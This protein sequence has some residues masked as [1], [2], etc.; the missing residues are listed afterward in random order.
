MTQYKSL[1]EYSG[2]SALLKQDKIKLSEYVSFKINTDVSDLNSGEFINISVKMSGSAISS[3]Y[4]I[5]YENYSL[6]FNHNNIKYTIKNMLMIEWKEVYLYSYNFKFKASE[7][8]SELIEKPDSIEYLIPNLLISYDE[9]KV[10]NEI[11]NSTN[12]SLN[13]KDN[14]LKV[15][16]EGNPDFNNN[17]IFSNSQLKNTLS[18]KIIFQINTD[19]YNF[20][21]INSISK[22]LTELIGI[23]YGSF[24][25]SIITKFYKNNL[26]IGENLYS[27]KI[28][29]SNK[30]LPLIPYQYSGV[31]SNFINEAF[32]KYIS[33]NEIQKNEIKIISQKVF[34]SI[35]SIDLKE[36]FKILNSLYESIDMN[37][38]KINL[39]NYLYK[40]NDYKIFY[41]H[42]NKLHKFL[43]SKLEYKGKYN[44]W[45]NILP[46]IEDL[47]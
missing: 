24:R 15:I 19:N 42:I 23:A 4:E 21:Y 18:T 10:D 5:L 3:P 14:N 29:N 17:K 8:I 41:S 43:L 45:S 30:K 16:L 44:N 40:E 47:N 33:L 34:E 35:S 36:S 38:N 37:E 11:I 7:I 27:I 28:D 13:Y 32:E 46:N 9:M 22:D 25:P 26:L 20:Q 12:L 39:D 1:Y 6:E 31:L 2:N